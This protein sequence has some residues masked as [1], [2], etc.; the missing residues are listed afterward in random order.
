MSEDHTHQPPA[1]IDNAWEPN[2]S[3]ATRQ[4]AVQYGGDDELDWDEIIA[5]SDEDE[6]EG[7]VAFD[8]ADYP[9]EESTTKA[10]RAW[11]HGVFERALSNE[12]ATKSQVDGAR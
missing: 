11:I 10:L 4:N 1:G 9:D 5:H 12:N 2:H 3:Y 7:R 8:S 6:R